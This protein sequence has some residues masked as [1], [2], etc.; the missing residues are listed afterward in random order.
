M[1]AV[2][3]EAETLYLRISRECVGIHDPCENR[4][5]PCACAGGFGRAKTTNN[6]KPLEL[7]RLPEPWKCTE[8]GARLRRSADRKVKAPGMT[9]QDFGFNRISQL[10]PELVQEHRPPHHL[11]LPLLLNVL[12]DRIRKHRGSILVLFEVLFRIT[13]AK[14]TCAL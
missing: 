2:K 14:L 1:C 9:T 13:F 7:V 11:P 10:R 3:A 5:T 8:S 4:A 6:V 12:F